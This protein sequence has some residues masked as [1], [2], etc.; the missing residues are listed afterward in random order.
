[1][2]CEIGSISPLF[3]QEP[4]CSRLAQRHLVTGYEK[5]QPF[6]RW[7]PFLVR[8]CRIQS[9]QL[10]SAVLTA[11]AASPPS[12]VVTPASHGL[13]ASGFFLS[14]SVATVAASPPL[15]IASII[16]PSMSRLNFRL[17][18][19]LPAFGHSVV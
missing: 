13:T 17:A 6:L 11:A 15:R 3:V 16:W 12:K 7:L 2:N 10:P 1:M 18:M 4:P 14:Q 8:P 5:G 9:A 19:N